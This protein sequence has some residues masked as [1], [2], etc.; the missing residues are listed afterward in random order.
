MT[1][2]SRQHS[3]LRKLVEPMCDGY[4]SIELGCHSRSP[5]R[6]GG[7]LHPRAEVQGYFDVV[8][9]IPVHQIR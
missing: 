1:D 7:R 2:H 9:G 8:R 3:S 4:H 5:A 6:R